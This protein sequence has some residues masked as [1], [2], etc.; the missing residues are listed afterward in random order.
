MPK[1]DIICYNCGDAIE[2][3]CPEDCIPKDSKFGA[4]SDF[5][6]ICNNCTRTNYVYAFCR[7]GL[8]PVGP[9]RTGPITNGPI[10]IPVGIRGNSGRLCL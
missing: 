7:N 5:P 6:V 3:E 1:V 9:S 10:D 2:W 8:E 4:N